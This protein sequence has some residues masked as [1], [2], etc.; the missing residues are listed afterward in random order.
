MSFE[1]KRVASRARPTIRPAEPKVSPAQVAKA[2]A[3]AQPAKLGWVE[4]AARKAVAALNL[5]AFA[6]LT[7]PPLLKRPVVIFP[8]LTL[9]AKSTTPMAKHFASNTANGQPA[10]YNARDGRFHLGTATGRL[11]SSAE[12]KQSKIF[13]MNYGNAKGSPTSK[14]AEITNMMRELNRLT[15]TQTFDVVTHSAGGHDFREYLDGR[16]GADQQKIKFN[17]WVPVGSVTHGTVMGSIGKVAG[18][19]VGVK[20]AASELAFKSDLVR[21]L[22]QTWDAQRAQLAGKV[23]MIGVG[24]AKTVGSDGSIDDGDAFVQLKEMALPGA[25]VVAL[26]GADPTPLA[27]IKEIE[28]TGVIN[29]VGAALVD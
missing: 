11:M 24:G 8:G 4:K 7:A 26:H 6:P 22:D 27:H 16:S 5:T 2:P 19:W 1:T 9:D 15:G 17:N 21:H 23:T 28:Y 13:Q 12:M 14:Q 25:T 20:D 18:G 29:Q 3:V 10:V